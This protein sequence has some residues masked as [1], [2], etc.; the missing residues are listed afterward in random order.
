ML[1]NNEKK[2][3][4]KEYLHSKKYP[5]QAGYCLSFF[6]GFFSQFIKVFH[7]YEILYNIL[8]VLYN[9]FIY[10]CFF[11]HVCSHLPFKYFYELDIAILFFNLIVL[12][13]FILF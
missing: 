11:A 13:L 5:L 2:R 3:K 12:L 9:N 6:P 10:C 8:L 1:D 7:V 4:K